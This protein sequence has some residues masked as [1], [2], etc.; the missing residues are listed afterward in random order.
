MPLFLLRVRPQQAEG[1]LDLRGQYLERIRELVALQL[2]HDGEA[3]R[4]G[5]L[6]G[7][8]AAACDARDAAAGEL[9]ELRAWRGRCVLCHAFLALCCMGAGS[10]RGAVL[11]MM[12]IVLCVQ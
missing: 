3:R 9:R 10:G 4:A 1:Q 11:P 6:E 7:E 2:R 5:R 8:L 12:F